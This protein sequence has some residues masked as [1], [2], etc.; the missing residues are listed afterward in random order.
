[1]F[2]LKN[3]ISHRYYTFLVCQLTPFASQVSDVT[4]DTVQISAHTQKRT[5][6]FWKPIAFRKIKAARISQ[7]R[8]SKKC[9]IYTELVPPWPLD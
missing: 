3:S 5:I 2:H 7:S 4:S 6:C 8:S 9:D 1:M